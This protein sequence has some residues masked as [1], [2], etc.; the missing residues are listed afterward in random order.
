MDVTG[1]GE[2][3]ALLNRQW[4]K[5][6]EAQLQESIGKQP[7]AAVNWQQLTLNDRLQQ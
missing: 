5:K 3:L 4:P 1:I 7:A 6:E 2:L